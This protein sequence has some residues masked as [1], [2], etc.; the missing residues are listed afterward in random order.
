MAAKIGGLLKLGIVTVLL[1]APAGGHD[2][3]GYVPQPNA[4]PGD[5]QSLA[6]VRAAAATR[7]AQLRSLAQQQDQQPLPSRVKAAADIRYQACVSDAG[8]EHDASWAAECKRV[9]EKT[10][11]DRANCLSKLNLSKT[12]CDA[13]YATRD[14][15]PHC[16]LPDAIAS[17]LDAA[18]EQAR[19]RCVREGKAAGQ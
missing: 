15:S 18:L 2:Y 3:A 17:V 8:A 9:L 13:S 1:V 19:Y 14:A 10:E 11:Q 16:S 6:Q 7:A 12:Y 4:E 5:A